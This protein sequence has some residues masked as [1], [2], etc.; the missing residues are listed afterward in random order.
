MRG[1]HWGLVD[2]PF[3]CVRVFPGQRGAPRPGAFSLTPPAPHAWRGLWGRGAG[4]NGTTQRAHTVCRLLPASRPDLPGPRPSHDPG[5]PRGVSWRRRLTPPG[6]HPLDAT[7]NKSSP[8][9]RRGKRTLSHTHPWK[10]SRS[11][12][13]GHSRGSGEWVCTPGRGGRKPVRVGRR[14]PPQA[15]P[16]P[17]K[18][19]GGGRGQGEPRQAVGTNTDAGHTVRPPGLS[20]GT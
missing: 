1:T 9:Q 18:S 2:C 10:G 8:P 3:S 15:R 7:L 19:K 17:R 5:E 12:F 6:V 20:W 16:A 4:R 11:V 14:S 13:P